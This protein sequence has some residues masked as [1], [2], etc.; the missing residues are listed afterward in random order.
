VHRCKL[1]VTSESE[2][3]WRTNG[4]Q[5]THWPTLYAQYSAA[6]LIESGGWGGGGDYSAAAASLWFFLP[7]LGRP[8][9]SLKN[10][11]KIKTRKRD[12]WEK[13]QEAGRI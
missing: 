9:K 4:L 8:P 6:Q 5:R 11:G 10:S 1:C 7:C 13:A 12:Q 2:E 3:D